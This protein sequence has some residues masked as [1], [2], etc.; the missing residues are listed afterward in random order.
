MLQ[1]ARFPVLAATLCLAA[2][3]VGLA[4]LDDYG[5][6]WDEPLQRD[7]AIFNLDYALGDR[8]EALP[9]RHLYFY[10]VAFEMP[11][12]LAERALGLSDSRDIHLMRHLLTHLFF[13]VGAFFC[14]LL[15]QRMFGSRAL[16][17]LAMLLFLLH[18]RLYAHSFFNS[19]D[20][21]FAVMFMIALY[22]IHRA[23]GTG[24]L[25]AFALCGVG[26]GLATDLRIFGALLLAAVPAMRALDA[27]HASSGLQRRRIL[28][29]IAAFAAA[30]VATLYLVHPY[31][32]ANPLRFFDAFQ[33]L[34]R[35]PP[36]DVL[37]Q[38]EFV[39]SDAVPPHYLPTWFAVTA[40]PLTLF[41]GVVGAAAACWQGLAQP[42]RILRDGELRFRFLLLGCVV[43]PVAVAV[44][45][46]AHIYNGWRQFYFLWGPF[47]LLAAAGLRFCA[48]PALPSQ[49]Q[50]PA[51]NYLD[52]TKEEGPSRP[53]RLSR[54]VRW[55]SARRTAAL[56]AAGAGLAGVV[57]VMALLHPNQ[58]VHFN[59]LA[60]LGP[61]GPLPQ[62]YGMDYWKVSHRQGY[63]QLLA[64]HP[65]AL[66]S[67]RDPGRGGGGQARVPLLLPPSIRQQFVPAGG[68]TASFHVGDGLA[69]KL[70]L[71][72]PGPV[73]YERR[74][75]GN[76]YL[77][78]VA[79]K[80]VW[81]GVPWPDADVYRAA[82]QAV[83]ASGGPAARGEFAVYLA[84]SALVYVRERCA[85]KDAA[86]RFFLHVFPVAAAD[87][88]V[89]RRS[90]GFDNLDFAFAWRG[91]S[92]DGKCITQA[93]LPDY[94]V[95]RIRTGQFVLGGGPVI[96]KVDFPVSENDSWRNRSISPRRTA[97][98]RAEVRFSRIEDGDPLR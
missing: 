96:W 31:Y 15:T 75:Y 3:M 93:P 81:G 50:G 74:A 83:L 85:W 73:V 90:H 91:G 39:R 7:L 88:P 24:K 10:G 30:A 8:D 92:F 49:R 25:G 77:K 28:M 13:I 37:F 1:P 80:M 98:W 23:Y 22:L 71:M 11:L 87:L 29:T 68:R 82:Y 4:V 12:L 51:G 52:G 72:P 17:L 66:L 40:P 16:A 14:G 5:M 62:R 21:P 32:W 26:V 35:L 89:H 86:P 61:S 84:D 46:Q 95:M 79:P 6:G 38:G 54:R 18:P 33:A 57:G 97:T 69:A 67:I 60:N 65:D 20:L 63:E 42:G 41:L 47:S 76:A 78:V 44:V 58:Q 59:L 48:G 36:L 43:L 70:R 56:G 94:P 27:C 9:G 53:S 64:L 34:S 55:A 2:F 19:K 45:V